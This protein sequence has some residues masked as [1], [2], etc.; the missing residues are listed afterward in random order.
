MTITPPVD[1]Q[2]CLLL[3][4]QIMNDN[5]VKHSCNNIKHVF[6]GEGIINIAH[7]KYLKCPYICLQL[8]LCYKVTVYVL[9]NDSVTTKVKIYVFTY[10]IKVCCL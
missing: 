1:T 8:H 7:N 2:K 3:Y 9:I 4:K 5:I 10:F 6:T